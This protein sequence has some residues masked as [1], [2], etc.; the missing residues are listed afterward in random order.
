MC[1]TDTHLEDQPEEQLTKAGIT[2]MSTNM[3]QRAYTW[4]NQT[5]ACYKNEGFQVLGR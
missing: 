4:F 1:R 2:Q 3:K 5:A